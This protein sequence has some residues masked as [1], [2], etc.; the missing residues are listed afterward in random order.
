MRDHCTLFARRR[1][2]YDNG[3]RERGGGEITSASTIR[4]MYADYPGMMTGA[5]GGGSILILA[6]M[7]HCAERDIQP[8]QFTFMR[9]VWWVTF[10]TAAMDFDNMGVQSEFG[11][12]M[13][14]LVVSWGL[15]LLSMFIS[16]IFEIV[17]VSSYEGWAYS[18]LNQSELH[19]K[20]R[21][22]ASSVIA[23]WF[24]FHKARRMNDIKY[25]VG[26]VPKERLTS[27]ETGY[28][29]NCIKKSKQLKEVQYLLDR[30]EGKSPDDAAEA[31]VSLSDNL[32]LLK[33]AT[34]GGGPDEKSG[35]MV[36]NTFDMRNRV[37]KMEATQQAIL[38]KVSQLYLKQNA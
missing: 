22:A 12:I 25:G 21:N 26:A 34:I 38:E 16:V 27:Q 6:F 9:C 2:V 4:A 32:K 1:L 10:M 17:N 14:M 23:N 35:S 3:Y 33:Q 13:C 30:A 24:R 11:K 8:E 5:I 18:W 28:A 31:G 37:R 20:Q 36:A 29:M 15:I 7:S 19:H